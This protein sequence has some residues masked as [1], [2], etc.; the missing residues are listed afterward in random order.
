MEIFQA[1]YFLNLETYEIFH[2]KNPPKKSQKEIIEMLS[3]DDQ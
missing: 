1:G 2:P 3:D